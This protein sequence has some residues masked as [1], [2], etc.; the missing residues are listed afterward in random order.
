MCFDVVVS[1]GTFALSIVVE[2]AEYRRQTAERAHQPELCGHDVNEETEPG[3]LR[4]CNTMLGLTLHIDE[5]IASCEKVR[6][7]HVAGV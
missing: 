5:R 1:D 7:Y 4:E 3:L 2:G 6:D